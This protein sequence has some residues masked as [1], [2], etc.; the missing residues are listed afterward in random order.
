MGGS[1]VKRSPVQEWVRL[2]TL[3]YATMALAGGVYMVYA[4]RTRYPE[5]FFIFQAL[6]ILI[7]LALGAVPVA[8][9]SAAATV[10]CRIFRLQHTAALVMVGLLTGAATMYWVWPPGGG[11]PIF[12]MVTVCAGSGTFLSSLPAEKAW[13]RSVFLPTCLGSVFLI[14][15]TTLL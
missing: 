5:G 14:H 8:V 3:V 12:G 10:I 2:F 13:S 9:Q 6:Y 15:L 11:S 1:I 4:F 7:Y